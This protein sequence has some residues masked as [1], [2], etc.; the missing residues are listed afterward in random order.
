[1]K[2]RAQLAGD[3]AGGRTA[4]RI[5][6][7]SHPVFPDGHY[8]TLCISEQGPHC[9]ILNFFSKI[10]KIVNPSLPFSEKNISS[11]TCT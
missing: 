2:P 1:M 3:L 11:G 10:E 5:L 9:I 7:V 6:L 4:G 8:F